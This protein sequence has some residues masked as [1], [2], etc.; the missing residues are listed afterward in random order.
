[1]PRTSYLVGGIA[2]LAGLSAL[3][4]AMWASGTQAEAQAAAPALPAKVTSQTGYLTDDGAALYR[5]SC[6]ACHMADGK[7]AVGA[8]MYP[9]LA[10]NANLEDPGYATMLVVNGYKAMPAFGQWMTDEQVAAVVSY[11]R[12]NFGN[13]YAD[14]VNPEDVKALRP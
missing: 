8:G 7:G 4:A 10:N 6:Q 5:S 11:V 2:A 3:G 13:A 12:T 1:M 14:P 9:A